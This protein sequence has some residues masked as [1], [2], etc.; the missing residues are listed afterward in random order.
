MR[1]AAFVALALVLVAF[2]L[3]KAG[4]GYNPAIQQEYA[5][6]PATPAIRYL[7]DRRP[8]RFAGL[9]PTSRVAVATR[10]PR[11]WRCAT[12]ST[13]LAAD[14][15]PAEERYAE[16]WRRAIG[17]NRRLLLVLLHDRRRGRAR[18]RSGRSA[19]FGVD[20]LLQNHGDQPLP[21]LQV[22]YAGRRRPHLPQPAA[23]CR[24][25]SWW[26]S[27]RWSEAANAQLDAVLAPGFAARG[28]PRS[29]SD[30]LPGIAEGGDAGASPAG[31][32]RIE[33][34][35]NERVVI[36]ARADRPGLAGA[37]RHLVPGLEGHGGR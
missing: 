10:C 19:C 11:T 25:P 16:I 37:D 15:I 34:Y 7:Q 6:Q 13:T 1:P 32:A 36:R 35:E 17:R 21:G 12:A 31:D 8:A 18:S 22:A 9:E 3:F 20:Y 33:D 4:S 26:G 30:R 5:V 23:R 28:R 2:D 14:V 29:P 24:A 27:R